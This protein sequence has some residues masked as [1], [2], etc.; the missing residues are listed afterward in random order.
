MR[1]ADLTPDLLS[2][3]FRQFDEPNDTFSRGPTQYLLAAAVQRQGINSCINGLLGENVVGELPW[4]PGLQMIAK[5]SPETAEDNLILRL[6]ADVKEFFATADLKD[7]ITPEIFQAADGR[8][9]I[10]QAIDELTIG[11]PGN[12]DFEAYMNFSVLLGRTANLSI[13]SQAIPVLQGVAERSAFSDRKL[14]EFVQSIPADLK[15]I[16]TRNGR[17][18][19][20]LTSA[21]QQQLPAGSQ[22][23]VHRQEKGTYPGVPWQAQPWFEK[24]VLRQ[25]KRTASQGL[26]Q[27]QAVEKILRKY[28]NRRAKRDKKNVWHLFVLQTWLDFHLN[29]IDPFREPS[30]S[31][32]LPSTFA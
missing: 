30:D 16:D 17:K 3:V 32:P 28:K 21:F 18:R 6:I 20:L 2:S 4:A 1:P 9:Q 26:I 27:P 12:S 29:G 23:Q 22:E 8:G 14:W 24:L 15:R 11:I 7:L 10:S 13:A 25:A 5:R 31:T 19:A